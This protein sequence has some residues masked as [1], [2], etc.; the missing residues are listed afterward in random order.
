MPHGGFVIVDE[1]TAKAAFKRYMNS[2][3]RRI[4]RSAHRHYGKRLRV[5]PIL[6]K[7]YGERWHYHLAVEPPAF[8][9][10]DQFTE[11]ATQLWLASDLGY[12]HGRADPDVDQSWLIYITK[13]RTKNAFEHYFDSLDV[14]AL[15][16]PI[17]SA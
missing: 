12:G 11:L 10:A 5:I 2:L 4:Y 1:L 13:L 7:S 14:D 8:M 9:T 15:H 16:N 6:E 3:N 17:A